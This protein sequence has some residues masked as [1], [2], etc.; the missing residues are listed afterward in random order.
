MLVGLAAPPA[1]SQTVDFGTDSSQWAFDGECDDPRFVGPG[2]TQTT[3]LDTDILADAT[4]CRNAYEAGTIRVTGG[5]QTVDFGTDSGP[6]AFDGECDDP[7]F[8]GPGMTQTT[9][10]ETDILAD[11]TDCRNAYEAGTI[12]VTGGTQTAPAS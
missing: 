9:L 2:M 10:L 1:F 12:R 3:L 6:W 11:A 4:D 8:V 5:T 7:R